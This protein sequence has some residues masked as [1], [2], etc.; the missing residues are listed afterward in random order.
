M[1]HNLDSSWPAL[2]LVSK[3]HLGPF[4]VLS[5]FKWC[6][7]HK[8][9]NKQQAFIR[10]Y[11]TLLTGMVMP[12]RVVTHTCGSVGGDVLLMIPIHSYGCK[13][14]LLGEGELCHKCN[15]YLSL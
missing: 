9:D 3:L 5:L 15:K 8:D 11:V 12:F 10:E 7:K 6:E 4:G 14:S 2:Q 1:G 13:H